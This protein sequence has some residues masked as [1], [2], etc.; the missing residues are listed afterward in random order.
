[1]LGHAS[2]L[3]TF[4]LSP[5]EQYILTADRDEHIRVS[6]FP[7]GYAVER[8]CL[9]NERFVAALHIPAFAPEQLVSGGGDPVLKVWEWMSGRLLADIHVADVAEGY[10]K[11]R[12][13]KRKRGWGDGDGDEEGG[14]EGGDVQG[15]KKGKRGRR[16]RK[17]KG[18]GK[19]DGVEA[20]KESVEPQ[21]VEQPTAEEKE[22]PETTNEPEDVLV[23]IVDHIQTV[24]LGE[25]G[26]HIVFS[27]IG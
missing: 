2:L 19:D 27:V 12:A 18:K 21:P 3:T 8:Y 7:Q 14:G 11:V 10:V 15:Q 24:D 9:G 13:P 23:F 26:R 16:G 6:W 17:G 1:M 5:D 22:N 20:E 4:L 25:Q